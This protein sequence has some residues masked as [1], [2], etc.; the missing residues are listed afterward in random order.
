MPRRDLLF[1]PVAE[2][3]NFTFDEFRDFLLSQYLLY[4][5]YATDRNRFEQYTA[6]TDPKS[7]QITEGLNLQKCIKTKD[8][9]YL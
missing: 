5:V 2:T 8:F 4:K 3:I 7:S 9:N 6:Q 1:L